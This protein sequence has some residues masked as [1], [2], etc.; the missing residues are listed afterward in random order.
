MNSGSCTFQ[1]HTPGG[2]GIYNDSTDNGE[3]PVLFSGD[4]L[5][6]GGYGRT[7]LPGGSHNH[8]LQSIKESIFKLDENTVIYPGHG[9]STTV[10]AEK[11]RFK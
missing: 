3:A 7:D 6:A 1:G 2:I 4:T 5:F 8:L 9:P 10:K 11:E